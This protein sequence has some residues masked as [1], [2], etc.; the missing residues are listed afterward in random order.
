[1]ITETK[2]RLLLW[3]VVVLLVLNV[4][5]LSTIGFHMW[6]SRHGASFKMGEH[7][8]NGEAV[9]FCGRLIKDK[10][11]LSDDQ[12]V[13]FREINPKFGDEVRSTKQV[14]F[15]LRSQMMDEMKSEKPDTV[16]LN[17]IASKIGETHKQLKISTYNYY[18]NLKQM[19]NP[20]QKA[21]LD[22]IFANN[23]L[24]DASGRMGRFGKGNRAHNGQGFGRHQGLGNGKGC[25]NG[26]G[27]GNGQGNGKGPGN[28][29]GQGCGNGSDCE[30]GSGKHHGKCPQ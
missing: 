19:C 18:F 3:S 20:S 8:M 27:F 28:G 14:L 13:K 9:E 11:N 23:M 1:M 4:A 17:A 10:L 6:K 22:S 15:D 16:K 2:Q 21:I 24:S 29:N 30:N 5:T 12:L 26:Q 25:E 7:P